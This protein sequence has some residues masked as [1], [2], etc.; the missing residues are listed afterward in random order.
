MGFL[1][2]SGDIV[3]DMILTDTG[4]WRLARGDGSFKITKFALADDEIDYS[5][6]NSSHASGSAYYD[7][8]ILT[9]PVLEAPSDN[10]TTMQSKLLT[11]TRNNLLYLPIL[12]LS[13]N[14]DGTKTTRHSTFNMFVVLVDENSEST[15]LSL[16][17]YQSTVRGLIKGTTGKQGGYIRIDQGLDTTA[18]SYQRPLD[19]DLLETQYIVEIDN[20]L[21]SLV[22][23]TG[24]ELIPSLVDDDNIAI[25]NITDASTSV[26][27][28]LAESGLIG[29]MDTSKDLV[30]LVSIAGPRG[31]FLSFRVKSSELLNSSESLFDEI[32]I[33][34]TAVEINSN[35]TGARVALFID[36]IVKVTGATTGYRLDI[37]VRFA[38]VI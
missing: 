23:P 25:Y 29:F 32:G 31:S 2:N 33:I 30:G 19:P 13:E 38:K 9:T 22:S 27:A 21:G 36:T 12:K 16:G 37:P 20:R 34:G 10:S 35:H 14:V 4:R 7:L 26:G 28:T 11:I 6:Y 3:V 5:K 8:D 24:V 1:D 15:D 18:I 17:V